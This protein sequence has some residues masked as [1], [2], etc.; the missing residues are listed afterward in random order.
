[1]PIAFEIYRILKPTGSFFLNLQSH[2]YQGERTLYVYKLI[3]ELQEITGFK[4]IDEYVWYKSASPR[5]K[6]A[7][8]RDAWEPIF[9]F[10]I[11]KPYV[12]YE[13]VQFKSS[14]TFA[15]K[16]GYV[17]L[18]SVTGNIGGYHK[19]A[20]QIEG[21]TEPDN[22]LYFP[23]ALLVKDGKEFIHPAKFPLELA[24]FFVKRYCP[25]NGTVC[26]PFMGSGM[27]AL[28][29]LI[30]K[31]QCIGFDNKQYYCKMTEKRIKS[32]EPP[33]QKP[34]PSSKGANKPIRST[35]SV[36]ELPKG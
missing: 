5:K 14:S 31:K 24:Q 22:I 32:Y 8:L 9:H 36:N 28:A 34:N 30:D 6:N 26:D 2:C 19:I 35:F 25:T 1:M 21:F 18:D 33:D 29:A 11:D 27:T 12:D 10:A 20:D 23:T 4:F 16:R 3:I 17:S 15:N 13:A 7:R